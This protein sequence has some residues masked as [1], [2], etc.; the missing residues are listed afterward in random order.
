MNFCALHSSLQSPWVLGRGHCCAHAVTHAALELFEV[1]KRGAGKPRLEPVPCWV[2]TPHAPLLARMEDR[3][4]LFAIPRRRL[5][6][7]R[8]YR[9]VATLEGVAAKPVTWT[10]T[11]GTQVHGLGRR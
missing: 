6:P 1:T 10:F 4:V 7:K 11:T 2:H 8:S 3:T 9:V 5:E